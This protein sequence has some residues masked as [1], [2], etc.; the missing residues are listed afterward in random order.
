MAFWNFIK[1]LA[2]N[3]VERSF[4][5]DSEYLKNFDENSGYVVDASTKK[6]ADGFDTFG[7]S[8]GSGVSNWWKGFTGSGLTQRDIDLNAMN[9]QNV[10]DTAAA[11]VRGY[12]K[13]GVNAALMYGNGASNSAPQAS[14]SGSVGNMSELM[15]ILL[16]PQQMKMMSAQTK[17][18]E[19]NTLK[20]LS[21]TDQIKQVME[22]Y[23]SVTENTISEIVSRTGINVANI[24]K[25]EAETD[26]AKAEKVIKD[27]EG[28]Y[29]D[30]LNKAKAEYEEAKDNESKAKAA[31]DYARAAMDQFELKYAKAHNA[32]LSSS[33][34][35][36]LASAIMTGLGDVSDSIAKSIAEVFSSDS[37][38]YD[39]HDVNH[40][41]FKAFGDLGR[42]FAYN[43]HGGSR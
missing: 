7:K 32:K 18:T 25:A 36:A 1:Q 34:I 26:L 23:P 30:R 20:T 12:E 40:T 31:A 2:R 35:L 5:S 10:E 17:Q 22:W 6:V 19:A 33:S 9:M 37:S 3:A 21:E 29:A 38:E 4:G 28:K 39:G 27:A 8:F 11:Q 24:S 16:L 43:Y 13:A 41:Y 42:K 15:Q 14:A